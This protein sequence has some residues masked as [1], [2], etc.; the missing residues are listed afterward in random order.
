MPSRL[1]SG[2]VTQHRSFIA[3]YRSS[4]LS[5]L[6]APSYYGLSRRDIQILLFDTWSKFVFLLPLTVNPDADLLLLS[7]SRELG[8]FEPRTAI[9]FLTICR[10][11]FSGVGQIP[12][13]AAV[14]YVPWA[15]VGFIFQYVIRRR[16]FSYW[17]KYNCEVS[18]VS[19]EGASAHNGT[20][21]LDV[22]SAALDAG[23]AIGVILVYFWFVAFRSRWA[24]FW[25]CGLVP[26]VACNTLSIINMTYGLWGHGGVMWC[27]KIRAIGHSEPYEMLLIIH[28]GAFICFTQVLP[29]S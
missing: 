25:C 15:I 2:M 10:L 1:D 11:I 26:R 21:S 28:L 20:H 5:V 18:R 23:T 24:G 22:L 8:Y 7:A 13:A 4:F 6:S 14:N 17:A 27:I 19:I 9:P 3:S 16:H 29:A 12:P